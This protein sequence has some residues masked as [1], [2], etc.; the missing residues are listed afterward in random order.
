MDE[1]IGVGLGLDREGD[2][3]GREARGRSVALSEGLL[4][5]PLRRR[6]IEFTGHGFNQRRR[7]LSYQREVD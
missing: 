5:D 1:F 4:S 7:L 3:A 2:A 6:R